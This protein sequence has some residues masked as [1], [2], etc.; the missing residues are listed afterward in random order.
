MN[1]IIYRYLYIIGFPGA[2]VLKNLPA[3][4]GDVGDAI[5]GSRKSPGERNAAHPSILI[6][7]IPWTEEPGW[8]QFMEYLKS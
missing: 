2:S 5:P 6:W 3:N 7:E 8:L 1:S 4:V